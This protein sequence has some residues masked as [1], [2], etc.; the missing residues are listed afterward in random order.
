MAC[1][2][3]AGATP[4]PVWMVRRCQISRCYPSDDGSCGELVGALQ[5]HGHAEQP[6]LAERLRIRPPWRTRRYKWRR[7]MVPKSFSIRPRSGMMRRSSTYADG[8]CLA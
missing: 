1:H 4:L 5:I 3:F 2:L 8:E 7:F 6:E